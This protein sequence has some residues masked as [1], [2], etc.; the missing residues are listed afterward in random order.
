MLARRWY[1]CRNP[2][3]KLACA[4]ARNWVDRLTHN[5]KPADRV[6]LPEELLQ[7]PQAKATEIFPDYPDYTS[8]VKTIP[9]LPIRINGVKPGIRTTAP[10]RS[11]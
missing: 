7:D 10:Q 2:I 4:Q 6:L 9:R 1:Q 8:A 3:Q 5:S 11:K